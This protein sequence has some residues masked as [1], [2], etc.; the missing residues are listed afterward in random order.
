[1]GWELFVA[2]LAFDC[3][4]SIHTER[5]QFTYL[6]VGT[7]CYAINTLEISETSV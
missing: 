7:F 3:D 4:R 1:M 6:K 2:A 5:K